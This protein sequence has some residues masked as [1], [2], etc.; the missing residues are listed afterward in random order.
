MKEAF[1]G[2]YTIIFIVIFLVIVIGVL[3]FVVS[4]TKAFRMKSDIIYT[5][6]RYHHA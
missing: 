3:G 4:Y 6:E 1:G 2:I 5:I